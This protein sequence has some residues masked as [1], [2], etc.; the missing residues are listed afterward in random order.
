MAK[1]I[2]LSAVRELQSELRLLQR[3]LPLEVHERVDLASWSSMRIGGLGDLVIRCGSETVV[4]EVLSALGRIGVRYFVLGGGSNVVFDDR[5]LR[6]PLLTLGGDLARWEID[7]D[8]VVAGAS[9]KL[10]QVCRAVARAGFSGMEGLFG[11]PGTLGGA[12]AMNAGA[13]GVE[14]FDL[15]DR[16]EI[17]PAGGRPVTIPA[18]AIGHGYRSSELKQRGDVV[19]RVRLNLE[20]AEISRVMGKIREINLLRRKKLP[21]R[22][23]AGSVFR[24]PPGDFAGRLLEAAGCKGLRVGGARITEVHANVIVADRGATSADVVE[25]ARTMRRRVHDRFG[26]LLEPE[27]LFLDELGEP[28]DLGG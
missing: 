15:L 16:V 27:V 17:V 13:Y 7:P 10:T 1:N 28:I 12:V 11:I 4:A 21:S 18:A 23:S 5:G 3:E 19:T 9:A 25:L 20:P 2:P 6:I 8:G 22:P 26:I 24:N 14:I